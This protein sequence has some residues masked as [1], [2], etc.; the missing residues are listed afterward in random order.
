VPD[1]FRLA[2][3]QFPEPQLISHDATVVSESVGRRHR[4]AQRAF[5]AQL[6]EQ[7]ITTARTAVQVMARLEDVKRGNLREEIDGL[8]AK[9]GPELAELVRA[10]AHRV[11]DAGNDAAHPD[12]PLWHPTEAEAREALA[13][14]TATMDWLY[15]L[16]ARLRQ[17]AAGSTGA[18]GGDPQ[19]G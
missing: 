3:R 9:R 15:V 17:D 2:R 5:H 7:T 1:Y 11:R 4:E 19:P 12:D 13:F 16:P 10:M 18:E 8:I 6:W 14:L